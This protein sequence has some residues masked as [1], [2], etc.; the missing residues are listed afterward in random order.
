MKSLHVFLV[1][2]LLLLQTG[3]CQENRVVLVTGGAGYIGSHTCKVLKESGF[4]PVT[5]D[6]LALGMQKSVKWGPLVV[7]DLLDKEK[8]DS[9][10]LEYQP[11]AVIH[12]AALRNVGESIQD[13][14]SYY[15][16]NVV[17]SFNLLNAMLKYNVKNIIF[18]S[19]CT[20]YGP[21]NS[22]AINESFPRA[23]INPYAT[24]K[25]IIERMIED[26]AYA[27]RLKYVILRY[28]NA[29]GIDLESGL[30]RSASSQSFLIPKALLAI[31]DPQIPLKVFGTDYPTPDGT[32]IRDYLHVKDLA[33][34]HILAL[35]HLQKGKPSDAINLG[36]GKGFSVFEIISAIENITNQKVPYVLMDRREGD[37]PQAIADT[38]KAKKILHFEP[39]FSD[40]S[41]ILESEWLSLQEGFK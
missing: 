38:Q 37:V 32:A 23:P 24:S 28:F 9:V 29:A 17:G 16:T 2:F 11:V 25:Y 14:I 22:A 8:L 34:A 4:T 26:F 12:F 3:F 30:R 15:N 35:D 10:F 27:Y 13:P 20:V 7:G 5:Y 31:L 39:K 33:Q 21:C 6:S 1:C 18:S 36:T 40:L 41:T 19:S